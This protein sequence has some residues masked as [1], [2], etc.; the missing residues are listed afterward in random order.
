[1]DNGERWERNRKMQVETE[2]CWGTY[3]KWSNL[4]DYLDNSSLLN[5]KVKLNG[6]Q[7]SDLIHLSF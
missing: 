4:L 7:V 3:I 2:V 6:A 1:M 5:Q